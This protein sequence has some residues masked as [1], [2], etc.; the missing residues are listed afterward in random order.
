MTPYEMHASACNYQAHLQKSVLGISLGLIT[1]AR[2]C[3]SSVG[4]AMSM[5]TGGCS[6]HVFQVPDKCTEDTHS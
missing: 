3:C 5:Q 1:H 2:S 6:M 4:T